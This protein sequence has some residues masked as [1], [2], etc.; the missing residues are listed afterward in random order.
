VWRIKIKGLELICDKYPGEPVVYLDTDTF[1]FRA[2]DDLLSVLSKDHALM[3]VREGNL[4]AAGS[5]REQTMWRQVKNRDFGGIKIHANHA[6]W[7]AGVV[8][9]PN[10]RNNED[11]Q[12]ALSICDAMCAAGVTPYLIEQFS[13]GV[14]LEHFYGL[15]AADA[16]IAHY[17]SNKEAWNVY[18][19][20]FFME[21]WLHE[22]SLQETISRLRQ[23]DLSAV[24]VMYKTPDTNQRLRKKIDRIFPA[25]DI[26]YVQNELGLGKGTQ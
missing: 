1:L 15:T 17:W 3:H 7:N 20:T 5:K 24:P 26:T 11:I 13:T 4:S 8:A 18:I 16:S 14:A 12:L 23:L 25:R 6:M 10:T 9:T 19:N 21:S 2:A 22:F